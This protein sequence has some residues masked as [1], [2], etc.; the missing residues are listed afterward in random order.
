MARSI[1]TSQLTVARAAAALFLQR[2]LAATSG[3]DIAEAAGI[4]ERTVWRY[5]HNK[6][7]C[8]A[9]LFAK[10]W[11]YYAEELRRWPHFQSI[12]A[13]LAECFDLA[14]QPPEWIADGLLIVRLIAT[15]PDEPDLRPVWLA[16]YHRGEDELAAIIGDRLG[17]SHGDFD[18][19]LCAAAVLAAIRVIDETISI[20]AI[21]YAQEFT[22]AEVV[23]Q[24]AKSIRAVSHLP[25]CDPVEPRPFG[26]SGPM[27]SPDAE[28]A[29]R[30]E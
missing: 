26:G 2:G 15:L 8:V 16:S 22:T 29:G 11:K 6:E 24:T 9:P 7:S 12:E 18:V 23:A 3:A 25:F 13:H 20:A 5:F 1:E 14:K 10:S 28:R 30:T 21:R 17:R 19:R 27:L 4:S